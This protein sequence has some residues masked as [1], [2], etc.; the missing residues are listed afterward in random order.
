[1]WRSWE[2]S[3]SCS[4]LTEWTL[5]HGSNL[6]TRWRSVSSWRPARSH[7]H[8]FWGGCFSQKD[9]S[10]KTALSLPK[11]CVRSR[12]SRSGGDAVEIIV[13]ISIGADGRPEGTARAAGDVVDR[14]FSGNLEFIALVE[15]LYRAGVGD[16]L[17][18]T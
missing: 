7:L 12:S 10:S 8:S 2:R 11:T 9:V 17:P 14:P 13:N 1:M 15:S 16:D 6:L 18:A 4:T 3:F 5:P